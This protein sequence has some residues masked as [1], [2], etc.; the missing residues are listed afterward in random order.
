MCNMTIMETDAMEGDAMEDISEDVCDDIC[1]NKVWGFWIE[2]VAVPSIAV[3]GIIG[4][5]VTKK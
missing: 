5:E 2:G 3:L 4:R 1:L